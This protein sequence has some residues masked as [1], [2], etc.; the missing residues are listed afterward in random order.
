MA[1]CDRCIEVDIDGLRYGGH[2]FGKTESFFPLG[3]LQQVFEGVAS[4]CPVCQM[5]VSSLRTHDGSGTPITAPIH[6]LLGGLMD[7]V[8]GLQLMINNFNNTVRIRATVGTGPEKLAGYIDVFAEEGSPATL[9]GDIPNRDIS[10][11]LDLRQWDPTGKVSVWF[12]RCVSEHVQC[13]TSFAG[14]ELE[15]HLPSKLV[16][17]R[18]LLHISRPSPSDGIID[19]TVRLVEMDRTSTSVI[20]YAALRHC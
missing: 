13:R 2:L 4:Q 1:L 19:P 16:A 9:S 14:E 12:N 15:D 18:R 6:S 8:V 7:A 17:P 10:L 3:T 5:L 11:P 20:Q